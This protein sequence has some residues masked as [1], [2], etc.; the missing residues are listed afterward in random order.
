[1]ENKIVFISFANSAFSKTIERLKKQIF[2]CHNI[3]FT[4]CHFYSE[5]DLDKDFLKQLKPWL[6]RRG[7]GYWRW[8]SYLVEKTFN[9]LSDGDILVY[10]DAGCN[11]NSK[12]INRLQEYFQM[13]QNSQS[14]ILVFSGKYPEYKY[15]KSDTA[16][17]FNVLQIEKIMNSYQIWAGGFILMKNEASKN[18]IHQWNNICIN[19]FDLITDKSSQI[20]N[21]SDFIEHRHDQAI[22]SLLVKKMNAIILPPE[23]LFKENFD[24]IPFTPARNKEKNKINKIKRCC[25]LPWRYIIGSYLKYIQKFD[26]NNRI[27]W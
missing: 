10:A 17:F 18:F 24:N 13:V 26:F 12:G 16:A 9:T 11:F 25:L 27:A 14:G 6:Y 23:E 20:P 8:K 7:Y 5:K 3:P 2:D 4:E 19:N 1:M 15:C 22:F 21:H